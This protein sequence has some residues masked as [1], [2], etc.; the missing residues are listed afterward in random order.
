MQQGKKNDVKAYIL[1]CKSIQ[2]R[3]EVKLY[4]FR[5]HNFDVE[6]PKEPINSIGSTEWV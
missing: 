2:I 6:N 1:E 5:W 4:I 3:K